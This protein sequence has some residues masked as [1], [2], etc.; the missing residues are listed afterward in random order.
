MSQKPNF[1]GQSPPYQVVLA[2]GWPYKQGGVAR[3]LTSLRW[4]IGRRQ[5]WRILSH[6]P[7]LS[8]IGTITHMIMSPTNDNHWSS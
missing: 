4:D 7:W 3:P 2:R 8:S 5:F 6:L 1:G